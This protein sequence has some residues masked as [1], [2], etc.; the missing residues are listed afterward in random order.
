MQRIQPENLYVLELLADKTGSLKWINAGLK[1]D[2][3]SGR[4]NYLKGEFYNVKW[5]KDAAKKDSV[6]ALTWYRK[7]ISD[8][9]WRGNAQ[10]MIDELDPPLSDEEK[11]RREFFNKSKKEEVV[12]SGKK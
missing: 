7:A 2:S 11:R 3:Q 1:L 8:A 6:R 9:Q 4:L 10:R 12:T 5:Q